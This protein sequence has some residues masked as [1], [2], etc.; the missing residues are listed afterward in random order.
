MAIATHNLREHE[1]APVHGAR[2]TKSPFAREREIAE[3]LDQRLD[4]E[5]TRWPPGEPYRLHGSR[6]PDDHPACALGVKRDF[7]LGADDVLR[8]VS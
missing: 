3:W 7:V 5:M 8:V 1:P 4:N 6:L 2:S